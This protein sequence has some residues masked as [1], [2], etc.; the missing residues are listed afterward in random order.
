MNPQRVVTQS[1]QMFCDPRVRAWTLQRAAGCC[2][3]CNLPAPFLHDGGQT[4]LESHHIVT[5]AAGGPDTPENTA[6]VCSNCDRELHMG[7]GRQAKTERL[8][9]AVA[10]GVSIWES[11]PGW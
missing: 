10:E 4:Y 1:M 7:A 3:L 9:A 5:L 8:R 11:F 6:A 2:E